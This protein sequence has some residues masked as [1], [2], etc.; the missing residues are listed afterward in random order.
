MRLMIMGMIMVG[1]F[2]T[3]LLAMGGIKAQTLEPVKWL[4]INCPGMPPE[5]RKII[6]AGTLHLWICYERKPILKVEVPPLKRESQR[7]TSL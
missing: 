7:G 4:V 1:L 6:P 2:G 5:N 3:P